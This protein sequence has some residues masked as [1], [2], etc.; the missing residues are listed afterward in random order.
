MNLVAQMATVEA[1]RDFEDDIAARF[2]RGEIKAPVHFAGGNERQLIEYFARVDHDDWALCSWR[3][4]F[5][6][7]LK[8]VPLELIRGEIVRG[9]SIALCFPQYR[10]LS[11]AIVGGI[12]PIA[13]G[14]GWAIKHSGGE[15]RVHVFI[16]DMTAECGIVYEAMKYASHHELPVSWVIEDNEIS[17]CT[18]TA[19][20]WG[21]YGRYFIASHVTN[22]YRYELTKPHVGTDKWVK[23]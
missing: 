4:H 5:H 21:E 14:L 15:N 10:I 7:L 8:G 16:G 6:C 2:E 3:S 19:K 18:D 12:A 23:F 20:T 1:L 13:I 9:R 17:V 22:R 11:S